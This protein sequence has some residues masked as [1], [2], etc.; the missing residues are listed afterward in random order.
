MNYSI[1]V[2]NENSYACQLTQA[3]SLSLAGE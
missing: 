3:L 1:L 2:I